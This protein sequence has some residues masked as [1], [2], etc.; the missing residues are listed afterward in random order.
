[1]RLIFS[2]TATRAMMAMPKRDATALMKRLQTI[3]EAPFTQHAGVKQMQGS[4]AFRARQGDWRAVYR[5]DRD[6]QQVIVDNVGH[7]REIYR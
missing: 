5:V 1:M 4:V 6:A 3:A 2:P 7:R